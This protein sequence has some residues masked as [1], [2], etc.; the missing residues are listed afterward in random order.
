MSAA[1]SPRRVRADA[2]R[3]TARI[4][5]A[6]RAVLADD[7]NA[8][9]ERIADAAGLARA[10][11]HRRFASR[12]ALLETLSARLNALFLD[13]VRRARVATAPPL[14]A[15]HRATELIFELKLSH[16]SVMMATMDAGTGRTML[17]PEVREGVDLL[18]ARLH[19]A[20]AVAA[21]NPDWCRRIY[22]AVLNEVDLLPADD[23]ELTPGA[24]DELGARTNLTVRTVLGA[25]G[26]HPDAVAS[27]APA[28]SGDS[29]TRRPVT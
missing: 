7:P 8:S 22:L 2:E 29:E 3:S 21:G 20:G 16:R 27:F 17:S 13:V 9:L 28:P 26:A 18:F 24:G 19:A 5:D 15:L 4:L 1:T 12:A 11:V 10:T 25:L 14:V 6:A 23:P